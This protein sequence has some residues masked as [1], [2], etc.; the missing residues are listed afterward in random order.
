MC[1]MGRESSH[2]M[3]LNTGCYDLCLHVPLQLHE[4][5]AMAVQRWLDLEHVIL[6]LNE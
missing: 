1:L 2:V 4:L 3:G 6:G 5:I